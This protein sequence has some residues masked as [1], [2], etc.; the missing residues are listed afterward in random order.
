[1]SNGLVT[2]YLLLVTCS[3]TSYGNSFTVDLVALFVARGEDDDGEGLAAWLSRG[4]PI[5]YP[6]GPRAAYAVSRARRIGLRPQEWSY[7][8]G[9]AL[10]AQN[11]KQTARI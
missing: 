6:S 10:A 1:M 4:S 11:L 3:A 8:S 9:P 2:G 5:A 7:L